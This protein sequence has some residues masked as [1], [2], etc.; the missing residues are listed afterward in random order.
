MNMTEEYR[1]WIAN[2]LST[3]NPYSKCAE[4]VTA[5]HEVFPNLTVVKGHADTDWGRRAHW[6]L[7]TPTGEVV[8]PTAS[9]FGAVFAYDPW[10]PGDKAQVGTCM[11]CGDEIWK[12]LQTLDE[13]PKR[14]CICSTRCSDAFATY[15]NSE[16]S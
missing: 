7:V 3:N 1:Q 9:Q 5:M 13:E 4:A 12:P 16:M 11:N 15:L 6:W 2:W 10:K 14:E 8:D